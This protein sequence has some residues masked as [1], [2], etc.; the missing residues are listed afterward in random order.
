MSKISQSSKKLQTE[1]SVN[2]PSAGK[3]VLKGQVSR[4]IP[5]GTPLKLKLATVPTNKISLLNRDMDGNLYPA[6]VGQE[7]TAKTSE[8]LYIDDNKVIPEGTIFMGK[9]LKFCHLVAWADLDR[10]VLS[11]DSLTTPEAEHSPLE[12][13]QI[14]SSPLPYAR[15]PKDRIICAHAAGGAIIGALVAYEVFGLQYT[16]SM[17]GYNIAAAAGGGA[18]PSYGYAIMRH[19]PAASLEPGD[20]LNM[21]I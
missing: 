11:F 3:L 8:D 19:G 10:W 4:T 6:K 21:R 5:G 12:L 7:I 18:L 17:H 2:K 9:F 20:D 15:K 1:T 13:T 14:I 16:I